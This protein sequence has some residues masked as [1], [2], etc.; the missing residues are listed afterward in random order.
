MSVAFKFHESISEVVRQ[1]GVFHRLSESASSKIATIE[2]TPGG[3]W[4]NP[5]SGDKADYSY[6]LKLFDKAG[7][8][9]S[10]P[11]GMCVT[12]TGKDGSLAYHQLAQC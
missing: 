7:S 6:H 11:W 1:D 9:I 12:P 3:P 2:V 4:S 10:T 5:R 8:E